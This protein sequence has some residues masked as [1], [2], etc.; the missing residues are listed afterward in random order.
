MSFV[1][2]NT[3]VAALG[4]EFGRLQLTL[5][6][7]SQPPPAADFGGLRYVANMPKWRGHLVNLVSGSPLN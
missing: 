6:A 3:A 2:N 5:V 7:A 4:A 1:L